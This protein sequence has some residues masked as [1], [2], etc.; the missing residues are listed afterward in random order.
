VAV[1]GASGY[2]GGRLVRRLEDDP[3]I[4]HV[5]AIDVRPPAKGFGA[6]TSFFQHDVS[7]PFSYAL[8]E[9]RV[10]AAAHLVHVLRPGRDRD[11]VRRINIEGTRNLLRACEAA[12][13][14]KVVY[15][16]ST[17]VYGAHPDNPVTLTEDSPLRP[18][19]GYQYSEDKV[20][21]ESLVR[22]FAEK[23]PDVTAT[24]LRGCPVLGPNANN[25]ISRTF[26]RSFLVAVRGHDPPMQ[27]LHEDDVTDILGFCMLHDAPG[28]YNV[29]GDGVVRWSEIADVLGRPLWAIPPPGLY[30]A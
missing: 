19:K 13:T 10:T 27:L 11:A 28:T 3:Q 21:A 2:I 16:S 20:E 25:F 7:E 22:A 12:G 18:V 6:K 23:R 5:L 17:S 1:T 14:K 24:V 9:H 26:T 30:W 4:E 29:A 15:L 8:A